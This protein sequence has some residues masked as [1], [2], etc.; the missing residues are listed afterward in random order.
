MLIQCLTSLSL[1]QRK[2]DGFCQLGCALKQ[3]YSNF[4]APRRPEERGC[5][6]SCKVERGSQTYRTRCEVHPATL[7]NRD[8][9]GLKLEEK[10]K[11][12]QFL[13]VFLKYTRKSFQLTN[14]KTCYFIMCLCIW[15]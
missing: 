9:T 14:A 15:T 1:H 10:I 6:R 11:Q 4:L 8:K 13:S 5:P 2:R 3:C 7:V 12:I